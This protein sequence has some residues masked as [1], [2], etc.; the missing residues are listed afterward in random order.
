MLI[1]VVKASH[2]TQNT[3]MMKNA[4]QN[5]NRGTILKLIKSKKPTANISLNSEKLDAFPLISEIRQRFS[6]H[7]FYST[8][9]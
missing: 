9:S 6:S 3:F 5:K 7:C 2:K 4:K 8:L 1:N